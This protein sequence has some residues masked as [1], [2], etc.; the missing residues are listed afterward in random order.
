VRN[1]Q[2]GRTQVGDFVGR[3]S[4][5]ALDEL[6]RNRQSGTVASEF[7]HSQKIALVAGELS[8]AWEMLSGEKRAF[9][10]VYQP[11]M[12][13]VYAEFSFVIPMTLHDDG[14]TFAV[15]VLVERGAAATV[16]AAMFGDTIDDVPP[17]DLA[18]A[19]SEVCNIFSDS[20]ARNLY[21]TETIDIGLPF[22][23][24]AVNYVN[25]FEA[26]GE[27]DIYQSQ[28]NGNCLTVVV[29]THSDTRMQPLS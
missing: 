14:S 4:P 26:S 23:L 17:E 18:D 13:P 22:K 7:N 24:T 11:H 15:G 19:C 27:G 29:F 28:A 1:A 21:P 5:A 6:G 3:G 9:E 8:H 20:I 10:W 2:S 25:V 12:C 16:A